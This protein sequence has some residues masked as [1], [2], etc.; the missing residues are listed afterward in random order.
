MSTS[1]IDM[2]FKIVTPYWNYSGMSLLTIGLTKIAKFDKTLY[3]QENQLHTGFFL[4]SWLFIL[5]PK[6]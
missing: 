5:L 1:F 3:L 4:Y 6:F 2:D